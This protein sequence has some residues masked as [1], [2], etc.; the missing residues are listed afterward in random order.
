MWNE[1]RWRRSVAPVVRK[2]FSSPLWLT[3]LE[4]LYFKL[5]FRTNNLSLKQWSAFWVNIIKKSI[6]GWMIFLYPQLLSIP[7]QCSLY[8]LLTC[9][10]PLWITAITYLKSLHP[11]LNTHRRSL[12]S[13]RFGALVILNY[14]D[15]ACGTT[16]IMIGYFISYHL[17]VNGWLSTLTTEWAVWVYNSICPCDLHQR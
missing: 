16:L 12:F 6:P 9:L 15:C 3:Y 1:R 10:L 17:S 14:T 7:R 11:S 5:D 8:P 2:M 4:D 13:T